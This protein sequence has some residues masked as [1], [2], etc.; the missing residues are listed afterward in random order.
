[1]KEKPIVIT[2]ATG[3]LL[4]CILGMA[5]SVVPSDT[6]RNLA[7]ATGSAGIILASTLLTLYYFRKGYDMVAAGY[8]ILAI[9]E[10]VVF[11]SCATNLD[12]NIPSFGAGTFLWALAMAVLS[13]QKVFP[14]FVSCTGIIAAILFAIVSVLIFTGSPVNALTKPLPFYAYPFYA[15]TLVGWAWTLIKK[16]S[17]RSIENLKKENRP[18]S[19]SR[20]KLTPL[21]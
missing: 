8:L 10:S 1:M 12:S 20:E 17:I 19:T 18:Y 6:F 9:G 5:G 7:W 16:Q 2:S 4:G 14:L 13:F 15:A 11:S 3:L 21:V